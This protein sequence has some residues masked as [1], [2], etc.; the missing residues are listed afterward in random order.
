MTAAAVL[1]FMTL[2]NKIHEIVILCKGP[3][4]CILGILA[5]VNCRI[6]RASRGF[7]P[8]APW[9]PLGL[10]LDLLQLQGAMTIGNCILCLW[11]NIHGSCDSQRTDSGKNIS[12]LV[13]KLRERWVEIIKKR[14][15][16][17]VENSVQ[18]LLRKMALYCW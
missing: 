1:L 6:S 7:A 18:T 2:I 15:E 4:G 16:K 5:N 10:C 3:R 11:H 13:G 9:T 17:D 8:F 14:R 12:I